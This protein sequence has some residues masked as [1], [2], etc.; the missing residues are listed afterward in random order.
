MNK[1]EIWHPVEGT[2]EV[3]RGVLGTYRRN[4]WVLK[5]DAPVGKNH[6]Q[7]LRESDEEESYSSVPELDEDAHNG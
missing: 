3:T 4:G 2:R 5:E 7:G 6:L 1:V